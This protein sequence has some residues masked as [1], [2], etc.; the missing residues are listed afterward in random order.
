MLGAP[1]RLAWALPLSERVWRAS[2]LGLLC[3][4]KGAVLSLSSR[5]RIYIPA[6]PWAWALPLSERVWRASALGLLCE[7]R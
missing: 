3:E 4:L 5:T 7:L 6:A 1:A 2:A